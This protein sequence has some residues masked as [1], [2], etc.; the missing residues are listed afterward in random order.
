MHPNVESFVNGVRNPN[1]KQL[2]NV[3][4]LVKGEYPEDFSE[5][6]QHFK[7]KGVEVPDEL[8]SCEG[9]KCW[10]DFLRHQ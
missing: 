6:V 5:V 2:A 1:S 10:E 7:N 4:R 8:I 9:D 3:L